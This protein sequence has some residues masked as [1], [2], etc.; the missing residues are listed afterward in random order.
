MLL[1][2]LITTEDCFGNTEER[3]AGEHLAMTLCEQEIAS[4]FATLSLATTWAIYIFSLSF[5]PA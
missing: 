5:A 2:P 4:A 1:Q 3:S